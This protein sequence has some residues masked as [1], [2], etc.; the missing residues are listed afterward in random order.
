MMPPT[1]IDGTDITG[2][3]ID[4]T[5]V[6]EI[7][8]DGNTVFSA[9]PQPPSP[10]NL[11]IHVDASQESFSNN[12]SVSTVTDFSGNGHDFTPHI[13]SNAT[14]KT[15]AIGGQP[16]FEVD[17]DAY[18]TSSSIT[19]PTPYS[20]GLVYEQNPGSGQAHPFDTNDEFE[21]FC[22]RDTGEFNT[23]ARIQNRA[24]NKSGNSVGV[25][26][27]SFGDGSGSPETFVVVASNTTYKGEINGVNVPTDD[28]FV[29]QSVTDELLLFGSN[30]KSG[31][32]GL[33]GTLSELLI[34]DTGVNFNDLSDYLQ[35]KYAT[36]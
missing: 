25:D 2:A 7:T 29:T 22:R 1:S 31:S 13:G 11:I 24:D 19:F 14:Y 34:Y 36:F 17:D 32:R 21:F 18:K 20:V 15:N 23:R 3:T 35:N 12:A 27:S 4:G 10:G 9:G 16:A 8:V 33:K 26:T 30:H 5:D 6:Q 28:P